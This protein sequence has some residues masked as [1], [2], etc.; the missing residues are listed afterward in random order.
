MSV[1]VPPRPEPTVQ[2]SSTNLPQAETPAPEQQPQA[3]QRPAQQQR[4]PRNQATNDADREDDWLGMLHNCIS[5]LILLSIVY[6]YS[7]LERFLIILVVA[8]ALIW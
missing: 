8:I 3:E 6:Y 5:F 7:S 2:S 4:A 1:P